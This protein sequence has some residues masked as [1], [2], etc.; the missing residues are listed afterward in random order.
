VILEIKVSRNTEDPINDYKQYLSEAL[1]IENTD[2]K[3]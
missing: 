2:E 1:E 3:A